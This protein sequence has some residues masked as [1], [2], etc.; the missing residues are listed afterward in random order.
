M[1]FHK[2]NFIKSV[3]MTIVPAIFVLASTNAAADSTAELSAE[4]AKA[5][6]RDL[7]A[8][9]G[10]MMQAM[11]S[12]INR[13][14]DQIADSDAK[15][16]EQEERVAKHE[17]PK[18]DPISGMVF[19]R[20]GYSRLN[21]NRYGNILTDANATNALT[22]SLTQN[23]LNG[24]QDA[25]YFGAGF[26]LGL[27]DDLFGLMEDTQLLG[28]ITI[29][30]KEFDSSFLNRSPLGTAANDATNGTVLCTGGGVLGSPNGTGPY[31]SCSNS[32][33][34]S[35]ISL[36]ASPKIKFFASSDFSPWIIPAGFTLN[37]ISPPSNGVT[38]TAPGVMFGA[39]AD[40][41][42]WENVYVGVDGRYNLVADSLDGVDLDGFDLG[43]Y[44]GFGF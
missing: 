30:Y 10:Q 18:D 36:T 42:L 31:A 26:E 32:V 35:Q 1:Q 3:L 25:W 5:M 33:T 28:E 15:I 13:L 12:K 41:R 16:K 24:D 27:S 43:G 9:M 34:V 14:E 8:Q 37:V 21:Q 17:K 7:K 44:V 39:G 6:V 22:Q 19:F 20:G 23:V 38:V 29:N 4:E 11:E 40:Y 2:I